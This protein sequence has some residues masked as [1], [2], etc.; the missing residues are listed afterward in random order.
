MRGPRPLRIFLMVI[1]V[2]TPLAQYF[3]LARAWRL[4]DAMVW[5]GLRYLGQSLWLAAVLVVLTAVLDLMVG[6]RFLRRDLWPWGRAGARLWLIASCVG[7]VAVT[8]VGGIEWLSRPAIAALPATQRRVSSRFG[9]TSSTMPRIWRA[10][11]PCWSQPTGRTAGRLW[12]RIVNVDVPITEL[13]L[14]LDGL[15]IVHLSDLHIGDFMP[16]AAIRRAVTMANSVQADLAVLTGDLISYG[17][18]PIEDCI[19]EL[20]QLRVPWASGGAMA[21]TSARQR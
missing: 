11:F 18:D 17:R 10:A 13:P 14:S 19:A 1:L 20:S 15:R 7:Y 4:I 6:H 8:T 9:A 3:W 5:P 16:R 12:Y 21:T 2:L